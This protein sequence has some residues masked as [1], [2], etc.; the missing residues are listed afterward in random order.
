MTSIELRRQ[1]KDEMIVNANLILILE[2]VGES[3]RKSW[4]SSNPWT[5]NLALVETTLSIIFGVRTHLADKHLWP[6][7]SST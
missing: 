6:L 7:S 1:E 2:Q 5:H 4:F 3:V